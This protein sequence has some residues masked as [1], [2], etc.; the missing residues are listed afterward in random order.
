MGKREWRELTR[1][2]A[3]SNGRSRWIHGLESDHD[4]REEALLVPSPAAMA[5]EEGCGQGLGPD[6]WHNHVSCSP[7]S[8]GY[9]KLRDATNPPRPLPHSVRTL[10]PRPPSS[11]LPGEPGSQGAGDRKSYTK[12]LSDPHK[13]AQAYVNHAKTDKF[14]Y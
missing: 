2:W 6:A 10:P 11:G 13:F 9:C 4:H 1:T 12:A 7:I 5:L 3:S 8:D 14:S